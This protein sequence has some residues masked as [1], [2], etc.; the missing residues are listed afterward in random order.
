[1][2]LPVAG[3]E[4]WRQLL[5]LF[6]LCPAA[7]TFRT[8][9]CLAALTSFVSQQWDM[10]CKKRLRCN[11]RRLGRAGAGLVALRQP[12]DRLEISLPTLI[13]FWRLAVPISTRCPPSGRIQAGC[14]PAKLLSTEHTLCRWA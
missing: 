7:A 8:S 2:A 6:L 9:L 5:V 14:R 13:C 11:C 10:G 3:S 1:M 4:S 12:F